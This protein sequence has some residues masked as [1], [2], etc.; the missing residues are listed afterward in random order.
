MEWHAGPILDTRYFLFDTPDMPIG[1]YSVAIKENIER[2]WLR[3]G[4]RRSFL[5]LLK[6]KTEVKNGKR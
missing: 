1:L 4:V 5:L 6:K 3:D 2:D